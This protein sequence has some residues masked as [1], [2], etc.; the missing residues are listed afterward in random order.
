MSLASSAPGVALGTNP[1][2]VS[3]HIGDR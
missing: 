2:E 1:D 3:I